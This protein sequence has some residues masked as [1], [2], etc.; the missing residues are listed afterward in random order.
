[1]RRVFFRKKVHFFLHLRGIL[2]SYEVLVLVNDV[3]LCSEHSLPPNATLHNTNDSLAPLNVPPVPISRRTPHLLVLLLLLHAHTTME[4]C[5]LVP[6]ANFTHPCLLFNS[7]L[8]SLLFIRIQIQGAPSTTTQ[9]LC[10]ALKH[11][12]KNVPHTTP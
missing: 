1:M 7:I 9:Q 2:E 10:H 12:G 5:A 4:H 11:H 3:R 6:H 8:G